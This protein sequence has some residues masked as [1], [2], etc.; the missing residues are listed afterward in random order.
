MSAQLP[1]PRCPSCSVTSTFA[2]NSP[3]SGTFEDAYDIWLNGTAGAGGDEVMI[4]TDNH[5]EYPAGSPV[6]TATFDGQSYTVWK[7]NNGPVSFVRNS[8]VGSG[9]VNLLEFSRG[10][11]PLLNDLVEERVELEDG[12]VLAPTGPG[13]GLTLK[14]EFVE[15][16]SVRS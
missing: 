15:R 8:N 10:H 16:V 5:G 1:G 7:G 14:R 11:N 12:H 13:L 9:S 3:D 2:S 4:W 6:T